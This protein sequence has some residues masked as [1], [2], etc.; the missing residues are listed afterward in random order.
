MSRLTLSRGEGAAVL[1][2]VEWTKEFE[3]QFGVRRSVIAR[4]AGA[5]VLQPTRVMNRVD[6]GPVLV[7]ERKRGDAGRTVTVHVWELEE[8]QEEESRR[9]L[10]L[11]TLSN[12]LVVSEL[13]IQWR[14]QTCVVWGGEVPEK[15]VLRGG[16]PPDVVEVGCRGEWS[17]CIHP[18]LPRQVRGEIY[19]ALGVV[20]PHPWS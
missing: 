11:H 12:A 10:Q 13:F 2:E 18:T 19:A 3:E 16:L 1:Q 9:V 8:A 20:L 6:N 17:P 5:L 14:R 4:H 15:F 7:P